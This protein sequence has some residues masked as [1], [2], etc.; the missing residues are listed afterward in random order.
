MKL[1]PYYFI[2]TGIVVM[3]IGGLWR[4]GP[5]GDQAYALLRFY[6]GICFWGAFLITFMQQ[7]FAP[8]HRKYVYAFIGV[9]IYVGVISLPGFLEYFNFGGMRVHTALE[10]TKYGFVAF[11]LVLLTFDHKQIEMVLKFLIAGSIVLFICMLPFTDA[12]AA[13]EALSRRDAVAIAEEEAGGSAGVYQSLMS[14]TALYCTLALAVFS[15]KI[16]NIWRLLAVGSL[17]CVLFTALYYSKRASLLDLTVTIG[18]FITVLGIL[19]PRFPGVKKFQLLVFGFC[20]MVALLVGAQFFGA[21]LGIVW[22]RLITRFDDIGRGEELW[23]FSRIYEAR[24]WW[25]HAPFH[26]KILGAGSFGFHTSAVTGNFTH[27]LHIGWVLHFLKGG[28]PLLLFF[29][30]IYA[31]NVLTALRNLN[32]AS[33]F[34]GICL[35]VYFTITFAHSSIFGSQFASFAVAL[36]LF[37]FPALFALEKRAMGHGRGTAPYRGTHPGM[38]P[39]PRPSHQRGTP[40]LGAHPHMRPPLQP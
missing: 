9:L 6:A 21:G 31:S 18:L 14:L 27:G 36:S 26:V 32:R 16:G 34:A 17:A 19:S 38:R 10:F 12:Q 30:W 5:A 8:E 29:I 15:L 1:N 35:P 28:F 40:P 2:L 23:Q 39:R 20:G 4:I 33:S 13:A 11:G 3:F 22:E 25:A 37:L 24:Y 7:R